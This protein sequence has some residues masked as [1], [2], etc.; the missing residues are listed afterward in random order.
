MVTA[1]LTLS[2]PRPVVG[3]PQS[4]SSQLLT[5]I[6]ATGYVHERYSATQVLAN[7]RSQGG[8]QV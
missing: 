3:L 5:V 1:C 8:G 2:A 6:P 4:L 7:P